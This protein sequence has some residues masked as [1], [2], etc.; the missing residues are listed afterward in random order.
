MRLAIVNTLPPENGAVQKAI[1]ELA[2][3]AAEYKI[4]HTQNL[5]IEPCI[6]C[7]AC[8]LKTPGICAIKDDYEELLK[9]YLQYDAVIFL[10]GTALGFVNHQMKNIIDRVL[11]LATMYICFTDRQ[12]R[13]VMR[14]DKKVCFG[15]LYS[16]KADDTY[17]NHWLERVVLNLDGKSMGAFP[18]SRS[19]EVLSCIL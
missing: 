16:G 17:L 9:L 13:H 19:K 6:G 3:S 12:L 14:Y 8:W 1:G 15:L 2:A 18:I 4:I 5:R 7:N 10:T 11:P